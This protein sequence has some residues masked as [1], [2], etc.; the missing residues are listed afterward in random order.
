MMEKGWEMGLT[1]EGGTV[2]LKSLHSP[3]TAK[4]K[5]RKEEGGR[6]R[7]H[8]GYDGCSSETVGC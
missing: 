5:R 1:K 8:T 2:L 4:G 7:V 3:T 6:L